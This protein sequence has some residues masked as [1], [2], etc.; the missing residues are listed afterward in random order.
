MTNDDDSKRKIAAID[1][2]SNLEKIGQDQIKKGATLES[3]TGLAQRFKR[4]NKKLPAYIKVS[5][6]GVSVAPLNLEPYIEK[7]LNPKYEPQ[8]M[9]ED[10]KGNKYFQSFVIDHPQCW[11]CRKDNEFIISSKTFD[12]EDKNGRIYEI[13]R[14]CLGSG[15]AWNY[16]PVPGAGYAD[17]IK[18]LS[19][20]SFFI[21]RKIKGPVCSEIYT[22]Y[23]EKERNICIQNCK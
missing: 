9:K 7:P 18:Q 5:V 13:K 3:Y 19:S 14:E 10:E 2:S 23:Y 1:F 8:W 15:C 6:K 17:Y 20:I 11:D 21:Q 22:A 16:S 12:L 4:T